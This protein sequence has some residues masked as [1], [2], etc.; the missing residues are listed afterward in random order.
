MS[1]I[2]SRNI[3]KKGKTL[4][5]SNLQPGKWPIS[6]GTEAMLLVRNLPPVVHLLLALLLL[7]SITIICFLLVSIIIVVIIILN[8]IMYFRHLRSPPG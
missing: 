7:S 2:Y 6:I 4:T 8:I 1:K 5:Q 3:E